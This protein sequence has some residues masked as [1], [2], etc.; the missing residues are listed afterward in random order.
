M[1]TVGSVGTVRAVGSVRTVRAVGTVR[2]V[3]TMGSVRTVRSVGA[4]GT[5]RAVGCVR[6]VLPNGFAVSRADVRTSHHEVVGQIVRLLFRD[7]VFL[8]R[9]EGTGFLTN[10]W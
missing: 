4:M 5:V 2:T 1:G 10:R 9:E 3:G 6:A 7:L 8:G